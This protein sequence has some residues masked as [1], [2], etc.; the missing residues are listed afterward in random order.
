MFDFIIIFKTMWHVYLLECND[1]SLYCGI[2][3]DLK[4]RLKEH[5]GSPKGAKYT[6]CR[7]PVKLVWHKDVK[8][9]SI[10]SREELRIKK[11]SKSQKWALVRAY[12]H[13]AD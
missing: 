5:N 8:D 6:R 1:G 11:L 3:K 4:R 2:S 12:E 9:R 10:A 7:R 13:R